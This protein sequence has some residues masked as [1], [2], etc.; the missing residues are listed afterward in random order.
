M[1]IKSTKYLSLLSTLAIVLFHFICCGLPL[2]FILLSLAFGV[3]VNLGVF[4]LSHMQMTILLFVSGALL[5]VSY[6]MYRRDC[7][8]CCNKTFHK[9]NKYVLILGGFLYI[10]G[11]SGHFL[12]PL[13]MKEVPQSTG[14]E[15]HHG[16][17]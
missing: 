8:C 14:V 11:A 4:E 16:C 15:H 2:I 7:R 3:N 13:L 5:L 1:N 17:H 6:L 12:S 9:V 10:I